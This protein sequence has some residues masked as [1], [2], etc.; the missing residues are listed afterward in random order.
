MIDKRLVK[1]LRHHFHAMWKRRLHDARYQDRSI[2]YEW[3]SFKNFYNDM[4][5]GYFEG[6]VLD[7]INNFEGYS[8]ANCQWLSKEDHGRK[9]Y[10]ENAAL[11]QRSIV[12][13][14][15]KAQRRDVRIHLLACNLREL[16]LLEEHP[17]PRGSREC[18]NTG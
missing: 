13:S 9:S 5:A 14:E 11:A 8:K 1:Q 4:K 15:R 16:G 18:S 3:Q 10:A 6:A 2:I 12:R 7:R 17:G